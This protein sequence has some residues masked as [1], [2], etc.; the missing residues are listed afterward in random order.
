M[1]FV[2]EVIEVSTPQQEG[3]R[4][5]MWNVRSM[6][7]KKGAV[8]KRITDHN[9]DIFAVVETW[10]KD[11]QESNVR[12]T[13][14]HKPIALNRTGKD[15]GGL[16]L[17]LKKNINFKVE[18]SAQSMK[19]IQFQCVKIIE[20]IRFDLINVY[21]P[22]DLEESALFLL[23]AFLASRNREDNIVILGDF[24]MSVFDYETELEKIEEKFGVEQLIKTAT[25]PK[26]GQTRILDH[27]YVSSPPPLNQDMTEKGEK[28]VS[29]P[30]SALEVLET[31]VMGKESSDHR[32]IYCTLK[33]TSG[34]ASGDAS[35]SA[36]VS[37]SENV[38]CHDVETEDFSCKFKKCKGL[39]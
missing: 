7:E 21:V 17:Y 2:I 3:L 4:I 10:L 12:L 31:G 1:I 8:K 5:G 16:L 30:S 39:Q 35:A 18:T 38:P 6:G 28:S 24:N 36:T 14:Y 15:G 37:T 11:G 13:G 25:R 20:P 22:P 9:F 29:N 33:L 19:Y 27:I 26:E 23:K 34:V 32:A